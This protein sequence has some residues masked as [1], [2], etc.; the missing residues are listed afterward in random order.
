MTNIDYN[1][2]IL[3]NEYSENEIW[4][5][6]EIF[7]CFYFFHLRFSIVFSSFFVRYHTSRNQEMLTTMK[8][9]ERILIF[10]W[11]IFK[12]LLCIIHVILICNVF[13]FFHII[14]HG[15]LLLC[16]FFGW[17][18]CSIAFN[19]CNLLHFKLRIDASFDQTSIWPFA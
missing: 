12:Y 17:F 11:T 8:W 18:C 19:I 10:G 4:F 6:C 9:I 14:I 7:Q 13:L 3:L 1:E 5:D 2:K 15:L 16:W